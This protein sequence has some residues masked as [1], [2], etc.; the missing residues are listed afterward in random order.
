MR[1]RSVCGLMPSSAAAPC[2]PFDAAARARRA[3]PRCGVAIAAS[4]RGDAL[5]ARRARRLRGVARAEPRGA[6]RAAR[7]AGPSALRDLEP[8]GR[9]RG[10]PR[11]RSRRRARARCPA[12]RSATSSS[13]SSGVG[14]QRR[15]AEARRRA[16]REV[17]RQRGD[18]LGPLAQ[19]RQL[20]REHREA[21]PE[22]LAEAPLRDHR[23]QVAV[24][25]GD[26][27]HVD[28]RAGA[29]RR[30]ARSVPSCS[31]RSSRTCACERQLADL[32][33]E[34]RSAVGALEPALPLRR[35]RR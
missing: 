23:V 22:V 20:D 30:R 13:R 8:R 24:R 32:V 25:R 27:A 19:R 1:A 2:A 18:V 9:R 4:R 14:S 28:V 11:A 12:T 31:T 5:R 35:R 29:G 7:G 34:E 21:V 15:R 26:D 10:S 6:A 3:R 33:E 16:Q 17:R